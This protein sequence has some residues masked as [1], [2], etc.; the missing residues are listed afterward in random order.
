MAWIPL[1]KR[2]SAF[3]LILAGPILRR[4]EPHAVTVWLALKE[5]RTV[6]LR[7]YARDTAGGLIERFAGTRRTVRLGEH[8]HMVAVTAHAS[9]DEE[10]LAWGGLY[11]YD[12]FFQSCTS[13]EEA[14]YAPYDPS[15]VGNEADASSSAHP[16]ERKY[17]ARNEAARLANAHLPARNDAPETAAHLGTPGVLTLDPASADLLERLVYP[18]HPLPSFVLPPQDLNQLR[19]LHG[20]CRKPHGVGKDMLY[21]LDTVLAESA[22][23]G[24]NR[25]QMLFLTGDQI[26]A[27]DVAAPL[28]AALIDAG[29]YLLTGNQEEILPLV[30][31]PARLLA[32]GERADA[33]RNKAMFTTEEPRCHLL[34][35][36][37][38]YAMYLFAWSNILWPDDLPCSEG[39][40]FCPDAGRPSARQ[41]THQARKYMGE[42]NQLK[43][44]RSTLPRVRR[45]LA[46][47][48][49]YMIC[50]DHDVTDDWFL[51]GQWCYNVLGSEL[52]CRIVRNGLLAYALFQAWGNTP[53][54]FDEPNG[55]ALLATVDAWRGD[56]SSRQA[57]LIAELVGVPAPF[58]G[59]CTLQ[60][61][62]QA[63]CWHYT[64]SGPNFQ[65]LVLDTR[66]QRFYLT[67]DA[68]P[69]LLSPEA[70]ETQV[71]AHSRQ[72][73][74]VTFLVSATPVFGIGLVETIQFWSRMFNQEN[75]AYDPE[76]WRLE[77]STFQHFL[78]S[79]SRMK[80][81]V[82]L[83][84]DVHYAFGSSVQYWDHH[85]QQ[86]AKMVNYTSS[87]LR[88][89]GTSA[90]IAAL[91]RGYP[92]F[93]RLAG[94][95]ER[96]TVRPFVQET[97]D[98]IGMVLHIILQEAGSRV[99]DLWRTLSRS[100]GLSRYPEEIVLPAQEGSQRAFDSISLA[101]SYQ[102]R[103]LQDRRAHLQAPELNRATQGAI[104]GEPSPARLSEHAHSLVYD[105]VKG[106]H[107]LA[108]EA[109]EMEHL[110]LHPHEWL[111]HQEAGILIVGYANIGDISL[112]WSPDKKE[113][114][115]RL[116]WCY[117]DE[118]PYSARNEAAASSF[119][120]LAE[121]NDPERLAARTE[122]RDTLDLPAIEAAPPPPS[123]AS[124]AYGPKGAVA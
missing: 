33:V 40:P 28:L 46:N 13:Q 16:T 17:S 34:A 43:E 107:L 38:Y 60:R 63:L 57:D 81:V 121:R 64:L 15:S 80:R 22:Q 76:A 124:R 77:R 52:G 111:S 84:G 36:A 30:D 85:T 105:V 2:F 123:R 69:G 114:I 4:T 18:G 90:Q 108:C 65:V 95:G 7:I 9:T 101:R 112:Q 37:E 21:A 106:T 92:A 54:Q 48:A 19:I 62:E 82:I 98:E 109:G 11:Y 120:H 8:L 50:D 3:P 61:S 59:T 14:P 97:P 41:I 113:V 24:A 73:T 122:Y 100:M 102:M 93:L 6:T 117:P 20:S 68:F 70:I 12:L 88:N 45:A 1:A 53:E 49:T 5:P 29:S 103:Y 74:D 25:P 71:V 78:E 27:D 39:M 66:T 96:S 91:A 83:S 94:R 72:E 86:T 58:V 118:A 56:E 99:Y 104:M 23:E 44:F 89:E 87:S 32:P 10:P 55:T 47:I 79:V 35:L 75:Y 115:Q 110:L 119:A 31:G 51:D 116:W 42:V 26:Y 67:P